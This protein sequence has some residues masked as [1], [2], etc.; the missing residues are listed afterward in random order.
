[1]TCRVG[2]WFRRLQILRCGVTISKLFHYLKGMQR[3][4][5][6]NLK[7]D[8]AYFITMTVV[9]W[10]DVFTR[11]NHRDEIINALKYC[12]KEKGLIIYA[13]VIMSNHI[14]MVVD[15]QGLFSLKDIIRDFKKFTSK[16]ILRQIQSEPESRREWFI[17]LFK[18]AADES[19]KHKNYKFWQPGNYAIEVYTEKFVWIKINYIHNNPVKA[20]LV[21]NPLDWVYSSASNY[22]DEESI[23]EVFKLPQRLKTF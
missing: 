8:K 2:E 19:K 23:L 22:Q 16:S 1:M 12:Q 13:Y 18:D 6:R 14:H 5:K 20:G 3:G 17:Q 15:S 4:Q 11:K 7:S 10:I 21:K 9:G